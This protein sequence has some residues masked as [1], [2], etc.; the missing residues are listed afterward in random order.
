MIRAT[1][2]E[3]AVATSGLGLHWR[4]LRRR[5]I[6]ACEPDF[7]PWLITPLTRRSRPGSSGA[8]ITE[9]ARPAWP[10]HQST[11]DSTPDMTVYGVV[12]CRPHQPEICC[13]SEP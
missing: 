10:T 2:F 5:R 12:S 4:K 1:A 9:A 13:G 11:Q 8:L 6:R 7:H 3:S